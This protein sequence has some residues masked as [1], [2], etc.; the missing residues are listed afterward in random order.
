MGKLLGQQLPE[1]RGDKKEYEAGALKLDSQALYDGD[2]ELVIAALVELKEVSKL[3]NYLQTIP[4]LK[5]LYTRGSWDQ[6]TTITVVPDKPM[7]LVDII[8][9]TPGVA[10]TLEPLE[11]DALPAGKLS[12]LP[13]GDKRG[14][15]RI[16]VVLKEAQSS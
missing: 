7:P 5:I 10:V 9:R 1:E 6:G 15:K 3:Y 12:G 4:E 2:V 11:K 13:G 8:L 16:K 14:A